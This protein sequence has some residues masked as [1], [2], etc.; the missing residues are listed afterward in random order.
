MRLKSVLIAD[1]RHI[2]KELCSW[3]YLTFLGIL[4]EAKVQIVMKD[5]LPSWHQQCPAQA[6]M[7]CQQQMG[8]VVFLSAEGVLGTWGDSNGVN[9]PF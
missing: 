1:K 9:I 4:R 5:E 2:S 7:H 6:A 3:H 8:E